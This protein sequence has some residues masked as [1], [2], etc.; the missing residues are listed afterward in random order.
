ML[1]LNYY[2]SIYDGIAN[3]VGCG[4]CKKAKPEFTK[5][6]DH[7]KEDPKVVFAA[8]DCTIHQSLCSSHDIKGYPTI[9]YFSYYSKVV[10]PYNGGR[11]VY[12][13][14]SSITTILC[15]FICRKLIS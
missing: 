8:V 14:D 7:F 10:K 1:V 13:S 9:K 4:H 3:F 11:T 2:T 6:A 5:A 15:L 12:S